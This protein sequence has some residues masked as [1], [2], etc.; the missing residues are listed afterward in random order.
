MTNQYVPPHLRVTGG[1]AQPLPDDSQAGYGG[2]GYAGG[3]GYGGGG[4]GGGGYGAPRGH[5]NG[6]GGGGR[7]GYGGPAG[8]G[9]GSRGGGAGGG[10]RSQGSGQGWSGGG[11]RELPGPCCMLTR[12]ILFGM[13]KHL[14][15]GC[16]W[17]LQELSTCL[18]C[19]SSLNSCSTSEPAGGPS[20]QEAD[21]FAEDEARKATVDSLFQADN[22]GINFDAYDDIP[23]E[24]TG[25]DC[26]K[27]INTFDEASLLLSE[28]SWPQ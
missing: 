19:K 13:L 7:G 2:G 18:S 14:P 1:R 5:T 28:A 15:S 25:R 17:T 8:G 27:E 23:V 9:Y 16:V 24:A 21:P 22:S 26:P 12:R 6:Y 3:G 20:G 10:Y 11:S 4:Y